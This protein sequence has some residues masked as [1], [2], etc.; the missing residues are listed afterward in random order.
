MTLWVPVGVVAAVQAALQDVALLLDHVKVEAW[1]EAR[2][3]GAALNVTLGRVP[4]VPKTLSSAAL[5][6]A[7]PLISDTATSRT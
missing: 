4:M 5:V 3:A 6:Q 2:L 1:P 7:L